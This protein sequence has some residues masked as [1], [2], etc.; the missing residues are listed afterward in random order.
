MQLLSDLAEALLGRGPAERL[1]YREAFRAPRGRRSACG[2]HLAERDGCTSSRCRPRLAT[3]LRADRSK[4]SRISDRLGQRFSTII[5][6]ARRLWP[7]FAPAIRRLPSGL[8]CTSAASSWPTAITSCSMRTMLRDRNVVEQRSPRRGRK[9][10]AAN[11]EPL[12]HRD[13]P[14][15]A[16]LLRLRTGLRPAR[17]GRDWGQDNSGSDGV[18]DRASVSGSRRRTCCRTPGP[19]LVPAK[20]SHSAPRLT[21]RPLTGNCGG[22]RVAGPWP[23]SM[24]QRLR[25]AFLA[26]CTA[27]QRAAEQVRDRLGA[28]GFDDAAAQRQLELRALIVERGGLER[29]PQRARRRPAPGAGRCRPSPRAAI[30]RRGGRGDRCR[31]LCGSVRRSAAADRDERRSPARV[32]SRWLTRAKRSMSICTRLSGRDRCWI[33]LPPGRTAPI[34]GPSRLGRRG[35]L[36]E[37]RPLRPAR[38][39]AGPVRGAASPPDRAS[40][41]AARGPWPTSV[42]S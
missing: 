2:P 34:P 9:V 27:A 25:P 17:N 7:G 3:G 30:A 38:R 35:L 19:G 42:A 4:L 24:E 6:P 29:L 20:T 15:P 28:A 18:S 32:P 22:S 12:A 40:G 36:V 13:G 23:S 16:R 11:R 31:G 8:S 14:R 39:A 37:L 33:A 26:N 5:P 10:H 21:T 41:R 1:T